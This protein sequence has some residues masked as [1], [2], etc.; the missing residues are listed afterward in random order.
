MQFM[1]FFYQSMNL[2]DG[3]KE[4]LPMQNKLHH[5]VVARNNE[6]LDIFLVIAP[7]EL[8]SLQIHQPKKNNRLSFS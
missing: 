1:A 2:P 8:Q 7:S 6:P 5:E 3:I 4:Q